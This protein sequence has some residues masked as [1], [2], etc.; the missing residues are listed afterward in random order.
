MAVF[1]R[2]TKSLFLT[3]LGIP[4]GHIYVENCHP[5]LVIRLGQVEKALKKAVEE[6]D[7]S[8]EEAQ[9]IQEAV[10]ATGILATLEDVFARI[11]AYKIPENFVPT[12]GFKLCEECRLPFPHGYIYKESD[13]HALIDFRCDHKMEG[14][15]LGIQLV[16]ENKLQVFDAIH[17][18]QLVIRSPLAVDNEAFEQQVSHEVIVKLL[19]GLFKSLIGH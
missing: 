15:S 17:I 10:R 7:V 3:T 2:G 12:H 6:G 9:K 16:Y 13:G 18:C 19:G 14:I 1:E 4:Y 11:L 8:A 5:F